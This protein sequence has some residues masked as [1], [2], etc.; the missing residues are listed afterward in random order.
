MRRFSIVLLTMAAS[1]AAVYAQRGGSD[2]SAAG[3]DAQRSGWVRSDPKI[4]PHSIPNPDF[5]FIWKIK[6]ASQ[7]SDTVTLAR[8]IGYRGFRSFGFVVGTSGNVTAIDTDLGRIEWQKTVSGGTSAGASAGCPAGTTAGVA[9]PTFAEFP[10]EPGGRGGYG[11]ARGGPA[12]SEV[13]APGEGAVDI[14]EIAART[15]AAAARGPMAPGGGRGRG[16]RGAPGYNPFM[17]AP[18]YLYLL[19]ADGMLHAMYVSNGEEPNPAEK[20]LPANA[21]AQGLIVVDNV[22]YAATVHGCGGVPDRVWALDLQSKEVSSWKAGSGG[23]AGTGGPAFGSDATVYITTGD[24]VL[25][26][27]EPKT[28]RPKEA[29]NA[30]APFTSSPVVFPYKNKALIAA[31]TKDGKIHLVDAAAPTAALATAPGSANTLA[32]WQDAAGTRWLLGA[33]AHQVTAWK[34]TDSGGAPTLAEGWTSR[35]MTAPLAPMIVNGVVFAADGGSRS[36]PAVLYA[37]DGESGKE[38]WSSGKTMTSYVQG[39][40]L[41]AEGSQLY[42]GTNDG[43]FYAFGFWIEH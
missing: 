16:G 3:G 6:T 26:S 33:D 12:K 22:A 43:T 17:R 41:S 2:W 34:L 28:L 11:F 39:G 36:T 23:I 10:A 35:Q 5:R 9:R 40:G 4:N 24:G 27:L 25:M 1:A 30:G 42:L 38:L 18:A 21:D 13:G 7:P 32:T 8:Y 20:F 37:L 19:S 15:A 14:Q 29:Y 31:A